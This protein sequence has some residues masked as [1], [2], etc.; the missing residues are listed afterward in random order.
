MQI[1]NELIEVFTQVMKIILIKMFNMCISAIALL[2]F[3][4]QKKT[5]IFYIKKFNT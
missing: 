4:I 3:F 1:S 5:S 2:I